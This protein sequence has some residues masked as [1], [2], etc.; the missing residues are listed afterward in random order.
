MMDDIKPG[1]KFHSQRLKL[2][3]KVHLMTQKKVRI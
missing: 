3:L 2:K 1:R